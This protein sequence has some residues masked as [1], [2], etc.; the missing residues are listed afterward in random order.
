MEL[1]E[2]IHYCQTPRDMAL[3]SHRNPDGDAVGS[4]LAL[5]HVLQ[6]MGHTTHLF[7]PSEFPDTFSWMPGIDRIQIYDLSPKEVTAT[8]E[9]VDMVW[10]LDFNALD[11]IDKM[12]E[13]IHGMQQVKTAL[14][15]HHIDPEPIADYILSDTAASS[16]CELLFDFLHL[17]GW[18]SR[19]SKDVAECLITGIL[20]DTGSF[21]YNTRPTLFH[22]VADILQTGI[23]LNDIQ[24]RIFNHLPEKNLRLLGYCLYERMEVLDEYH[25]AI[26][27]LSKED[28]KAY[29]IQRGDTEGIVNY[30]LMMDK[31][32]FAVFITE[33]PTIIK[34]SF[35][36]LGD[37]SVQEFARKHFKGGGHKNASGGFVYGNLQKTIENIKSLLPLYADKLKND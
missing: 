28:F 27:G 18:Q 32:K 20:T 26:I 25:T 21:R 23:E 31:V 4:L 16:T 24:T 29:N 37:F 35:R 7:L 19:I 13:I 6:S 33:Q 14:I 2:L 9:Q 10:M 8:L 1:A 12:G 36:S 3:V 30:M 5:A 11:R 34:L 15:D 22:K 17:A